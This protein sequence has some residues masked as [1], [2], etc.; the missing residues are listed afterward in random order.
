MNVMLVED[1]E[2]VREVIADVLRDEGLQV[3]EFADPE[4]AL[5]ASAPPDI[6]VTDIILNSQLNGF[7]VAA[8]AHHR[9][10]SVRIILVSGAEYDNLQLE[11]GDHYLQKPFGVSKL[12][13]T[14]HEMTA[15]IT[16]E[17]VSKSS[18]L[19]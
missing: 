18:F 19:F 12:L 5:A 4:Q 9:W 2:L 17:R 6:I 15:G 13:E 7:A 14:V 16:M 8:L 3:M 11:P 10:P 1:N